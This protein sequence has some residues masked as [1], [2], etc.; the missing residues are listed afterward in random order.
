[1]P[2]F[3]EVAKRLSPKG[4]AI[5]IGSVVAGIAFLMVVMSMASKPS[6]STLEVGIDPAQ[7]GKITQHP[8][9]QGISYQLQTGTA[10]A[11]DSS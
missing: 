10:V 5:I 2:N 3:G 7:T 11:V 1:M 9:G 6:Y 4:W 8:L